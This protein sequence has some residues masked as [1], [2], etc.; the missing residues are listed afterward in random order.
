M[1]NGFEI[2]INEESFKSKEQGEQNWILYQG[3]QTINTALGMIN[4]EG[5]EY[6]RKKRKLGTLR[7]ISAVSGG[8]TMALGIVYILWHMTC[9]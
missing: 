8:V 5:C 1:T 6:A 7:W 4:R 3:V 9:K 2:H